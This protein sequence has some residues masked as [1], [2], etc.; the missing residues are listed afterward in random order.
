[1]VNTTIANSLSMKGLIRATSNEHVNINGC[2][3]TRLVA[4][5]QAALLFLV[6]NEN[7]NVVIQNSKIEDTMSKSSLI[8]MTFSNLIVANSSFNGNY[9]TTSSNGISMIYSNVEMWNSTIDNAVNRINF[10]EIM[11]KSV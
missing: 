9:A 6:Q 11:I 7:G 10:P 5:D 4:E 3:F 2:N 8:S 1:M